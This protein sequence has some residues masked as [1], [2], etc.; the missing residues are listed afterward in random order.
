MS[1]LFQNLL[2]LLAVGV[3]L[4]FVVVQARRALNG[5]KS[6]LGSCSASCGGCGSTDQKTSPA[7]NTPATRVVFLPAANLGASKRLTK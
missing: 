3:C 1:L 5:Q 7:A 4:A 6:S 2:V